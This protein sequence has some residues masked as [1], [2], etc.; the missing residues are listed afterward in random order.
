MS[1]ALQCLNCGSHDTEI[2]PTDTLF[3][4]WDDGYFMECN[5]CGHK[6]EANEDVINVDKE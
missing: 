2:C 3:G 1:F 4:F 5:K 6:S